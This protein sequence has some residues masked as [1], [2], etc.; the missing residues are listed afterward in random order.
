MPPTCSSHLANFKSSHI[1]S[2]SENDIG[3][4]L[5]SFCGYLMTNNVSTS[6]GRKYCG[7]LQMRIKTVIQFH[8]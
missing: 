2:H 1:L 8:V 3:G 4:F 6:T 7:S 5:S